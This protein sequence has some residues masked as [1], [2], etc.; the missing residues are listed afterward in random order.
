MEAGSSRKNHLGETFALDLRSLAIFRMG[1]A[2]IILYELFRRSFEISFFYTDQGATPREVLWNSPFPMGIVWWLSPHMISGSFAWQVF[3]FILSALAG[4]ALLLGY[5]TRWAVAISWFLLMGSH[6]RQPMILQGNDV[7]LRC[8]L[9]WSLFVPLG[10]RFSLDSLSKATTIYKSNQVLSWGTA[11]I[12]I[13]LCILYFN[14]AIPKISYEWRGDFNALYYVISMD[15]FTKPLGYWILQYP[16]ILKLL[17]KGTLLLEIAVPFL[18]LMPLG[19]SLLRLIC[20]AMMA[21]FHIGI[22]LCM[23]VGLFSIMCLVYWLV[24]LPG[25][26]WDKVRSILPSRFP[27]T[28]TNS[29]S[30]DVIATPGPKWL[31]PCLIIFVIIM[32]YQRY[33]NPPMATDEATMV[34]TIG[35][36]TG[37]DQYWAMFSP[38]VLKDGLKIWA[39]GTKKDGS[40]VNLFNPG[41][42]NRNTDRRIIWTNEDSYARKRFLIWGLYEF[43]RDPFSRAFLKMML[44]QWNQSHEVNDRIISARIISLKTQTPAPY[45]TLEAPVIIEKVLFEYIPETTN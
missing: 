5:Q 23:D 42:D 13:Q 39:E 10:A 20:F 30:L 18:L 35:R 41:L 12:I 19:N 32:N 14:A 4:I 27:G 21:G 16:E 31:I 29:N 3:L 17:T 2:L 1:M 43:P 44:E 15:Y 33:L 8:A 11:A 22:Y 28:E 7:L 26:F 24:L 40:K 9:F 37:L 36:I 45:Q 34:D 38:G 6:A 25:L